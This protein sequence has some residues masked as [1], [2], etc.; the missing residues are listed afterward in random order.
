MGGKLAVLA[1]TC[2]LPAVAFTSHTEACD[3]GLDGEVHQAS[4][5]QIGPIEPLAIISEQP[6][7]LKNPGL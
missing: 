7:S 4:T 5:L 1:E 2:N 6:D 3:G